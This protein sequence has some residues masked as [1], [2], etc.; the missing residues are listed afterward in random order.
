MKFK[1]LN[2]PQCSNIIRTKCNTVITYH[3]KQF[4]NM[5]HQEIR[6]NKQLILI[7]RCVSKV[8]WEALPQTVEHRDRERWS[9]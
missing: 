7:P 1:T 4:C 8:K 3:V 2:D 5:Y 6:I 9:I